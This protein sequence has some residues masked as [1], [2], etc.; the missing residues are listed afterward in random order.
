MFVSR[1][2][3]IW[4]W[5]DLLTL[6]LQNLIQS[7]LGVTHHLSQVD[8]CRR[9]SLNFNLKIKLSYFSRRP[10]FIKIMICN[11]K[12]FFIFTFEIQCCCWPPSNVARQQLVIITHITTSLLLLCFTDF[13]KQNS[14]S[15][16][17]WWRWVLSSALCLDW[18]PVIV[19][20]ESVLNIYKIIS[21][22]SIIPLWERA[23]SVPAEFYLTWKVT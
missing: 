15:K 11:L 6:I 8:S 16:C 17:R 20:S 10:T 7:S 5:L 1:A 21:V 18:C 23:V 12:I 19:L 14:H 3:D 4:A 9:D 22:I 13:H 2:P